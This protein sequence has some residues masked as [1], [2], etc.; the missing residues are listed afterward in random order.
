M[1]S[2]NALDYGRVRRDFP[3]LGV[4]MHG[5][6]LVYLDSA[7]SALKPQRVIDRIARYYAFEHS[8]VHRGVHGLSQAAT[9]EYEA[10]RARVARHIRARHAHEII[11]T[12]GTTEAVNLVAATY[13]RTFI[14]EGDE[15]LL[16]VMEH[17]SNL[18]P[19]HLLASETGA[20][21]VVADVTSDG[22][23]DLDA[24]AAM[25]TPRT[26]LIAVAHV[27]NSLGTINPVQAITH[28]AHE[29]EIPVLIDGAQALPHLRV[30]VQDLDCDFYC[31]SG[32][33]AYGP[34]GIGFLYGKE[35]LLESMPP[36]Q[37]GGD[38]IDQVTRHGA[39][40]ADLPHKM[41]AGTP[42]IAGAIGMAEALDY[43][44]ACGLDAV[45]TSERAVLDYAVAKLREVS[46][47]RLIGT[48]AERTGVVSF[49]LDGMH[50]YD[51]G[52]L[53]DQAGIAV[54]TG[55]HCTMPLMA[56]LDIPGT[57]RASFGLYNH[58]Q[59]VDALVDR[60]HEVVRAGS[61]KRNG[62]GSLVPIAGTI[63]SRKAAMLEELALF[64]AVDDR[65]EYLIELGEEL[66]ALDD[67][68]K[69]EQYRIHGCLAMVWLHS[70]VDRGRIYFCADSDAFITKGM[71]ALLIH[72]L[73]GQ[74]AADIVRTDLMEL[75]R[76]VGLPELIT[77]RRKNGLGRMMD[78]IRQDALN[79]HA[80]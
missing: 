49:T 19:W 77:A 79:L 46:G 15:I 28:L 7:A 58:A 21:V 70:R 23:L 16:T 41:E 18:V 12:R 48:A 80:A 62:S 4:R 43:M 65:R 52:Q 8:N 73:D 74:P 56:H 17:H 75:V 25:V 24:F 47:L 31:A 51:V 14:A 35:A 38:M 5:R 29:R 54:R 57:V 76:E 33:K 36:W 40:W 2:Q 37:G 64:D 68:F 32:H 60:L 34:T 59:D 61:G 10:A 3:T 20:R 13:G 45:H 11:L 72:L 53:L 27:S 71:I 1:A 30:D 9:E 55:H 22:E 78:R 44:D 6:S 42:N 66:P 50:P 26:R 69:T 39:T 63:E 67:A